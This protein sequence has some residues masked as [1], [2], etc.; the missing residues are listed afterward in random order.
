MSNIATLPLS[1][2][3]REHFTLSIDA[4]AELLA[5][6]ENLGY[7][8]GVHDADIDMQRAYDLRHGHWLVQG[9]RAK[10]WAARVRLH[11]QPK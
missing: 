9:S 2:V 4:I 1:T 5:E 3:A 7:R 10:L 8:R 11:M 6:A